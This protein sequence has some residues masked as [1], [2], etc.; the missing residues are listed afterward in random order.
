VAQDAFFL[1]AFAR[2]YALAAAKSEDLADIREFHALMGG[3]LDELSL[4]A[5]Y[6]GIDLGA[7]DPYAETQ[8]Y[9]EFLLST[10]W[11]SDVAGLLA[12]MTPCMRLYAYL[13]Q[14]LSV[15]S[16]AENPYVDWIATY[17]SDGFEELATRIE[18]LLNAVG[19][20]VPRLQ[21]T[22]RLALECELAFFSAPFEDG[23]A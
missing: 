12:A 1:R 3:T 21:K 8:S 17:S 2:A 19:G 14:E 4:H 11:R 20:D 6:L 5:R 16:T 10:A 9:T 7:V 18:A 22:Y 13:G 15:H 23:G